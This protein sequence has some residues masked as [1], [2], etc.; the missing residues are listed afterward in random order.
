MSSTSLDIL[1]LPVLAFLAYSQ[2][3]VIEYRKLF[4]LF[5][6][7]FYNLKTNNIIILSSI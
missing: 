4:L 7:N 2:I 3:H 5:L 6:G 1:N